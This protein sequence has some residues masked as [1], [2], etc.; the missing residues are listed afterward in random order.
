[1][2]FCSVYTISQQIHYSDSLLISYSSYMSRGMHVIIRKPSFV[3]PVLFFLLVDSS[4]SDSLCSRLGTH[5]LFHLRRS[6]KQAEFFLFT[7]PMKMEQGVPTRRHIK[8]RRRRI[9][10]IKNTTSTAWRKFEIKCLNVIYHLLPICHV[11][12]LIQIK[13]QWPLS[14]CFYLIFSRVFLYPANLR[15]RHPQCRSLFL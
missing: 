6:S 12:E 8:F 13:T 5:C 1:V 10:Q 3:C 15:K 7:R 14:G 11:W 4:A 9:T 2:N